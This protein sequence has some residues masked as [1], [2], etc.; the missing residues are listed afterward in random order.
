MKKKLASKRRIQRRKCRWYDFYMEAC[1]NNRTHP[2]RILVA[3]AVCFV[4]PQCAPC[5]GCGY[6][7][8]TKDAPRW[9]EPKGERRTNEHP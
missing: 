9:D 3:G 8:A 7:P 5:D 6:E 1:R 2:N 4:E